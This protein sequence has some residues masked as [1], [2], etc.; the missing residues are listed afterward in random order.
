MGG[1]TRFGEFL[2][3]M[4]LVCRVS[5]QVKVQGF[6]G[7]TV[8]LPCFYNEDDPLPKT[9]SVFWRD[10]DDS[11]VLDIIQNVPDLST[12]NQKFR[13]RVLSFLDQ[14]K[15]GNF[16]I[17]LNNVQRSDSSPY[18]CHIPEVDFE[19]HVSLTVSGRRVEVAAATP[20][21]PSGGAAVT[22]HP[23]L[24]ILLSVPLSLSFSSV[25]T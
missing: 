11:N 8:L 13:G 17:V 5:C 10:K 23:L 16:S 9:V 24:L 2:L 6:V 1:L 22:P 20:P 25:R 4:L 15:E 3:W 7:D 12:Q 21:G 14:Y 19:Q 18:E